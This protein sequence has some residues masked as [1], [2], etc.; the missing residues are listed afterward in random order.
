MVSDKPRSRSKMSRAERKA[1][2]RATAHPVFQRFFVARDVLVRYCRLPDP[3]E[4]EEEGG[5]LVQLRALR[6]Q[7]VEL[8]TLI[9]Q[10]DPRRGSDLVQSLID[11]CMTIF[12]DPRK[13]TVGDD[14]PSWSI[15]AANAGAILSTA[16]GRA[17]K[18]KS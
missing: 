4:P 14:E 13:R 16:A 6:D 9:H 3:P 8:F 12:I 17:I 7:F 2:D 18:V 5:R 1:A 11:D 10:L 15:R